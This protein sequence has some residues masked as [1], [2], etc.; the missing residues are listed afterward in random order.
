MTIPGSGKTK[1]RRSPILSIYEV[2]RVL[3]VSVRSAYRI[4]R[5]IRQY[6]AKPR[7]APITIYDLAWWLGVP[8]EKKILELLGQN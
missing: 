7:R 1:K 3:G 6:R 5:T 2:A 8:D 4:A